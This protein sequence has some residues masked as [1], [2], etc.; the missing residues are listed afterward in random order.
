MGGAV[1]VRKL[2]SQA[3]F[4]M[5]LALPWKI[6]RDDPNWVPPLE[7]DIREKVD[8]RKNPFYEHA[9]REVF[10]AFRGQEVV[11]RVAAILDHNHNSFHNEKVVF[12]GLYESLK[13]PEAARALL[14]A[15]AEWGLKQGLTELRGPV[16]ISL[17][18]ECAFLLEG[19]DSP[20]VVMM[21]YNPRYYL[22]LMETCGLAKAKDLN[23]FLISRDHETTQKVQAMIADIRQKT[24]VTC[25]SFNKKKWA[26]EAEKIKFVYN[27]AW[28]KN[29]G[30]VP[31]TEKEIDHT[32]HKMVQL[33]D[34]SIVILAEDKGRPVGFA[35]GFPNYNEVLRH[36]KGRLTPLAML[37]F[38]YYKR[39]IRGMRALVF[40]ILKDYRQSGV[41]YLLYDALERNGQARG[42]RWCDSSWT[43]E[44]NEAI[45]RF[46]ASLG[47]KVYKK[48]RI[49][50][51]PIA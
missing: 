39:K 47:G 28:E 16:N 12:F 50:S 4:R 38:L 3:D 33:A 46:N 44:D 17:N 5:F 43:L 18:D 32:V 14:E 35:F 25:R 40:G 26:E 42:Y 37:K 24:T 13:D 1:S 36:L 10:L 48:Y 45:N 15:A 31:W 6:Y 49:F 2:S 27:N 7:S 41:S 34:S 22:E 9:D 23:A 21:P 30:F 8:R 29:W 19:F 20:P 11:G 51:K